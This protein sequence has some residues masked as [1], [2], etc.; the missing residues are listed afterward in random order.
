MAG[1]EGLLDIF[2]RH[3]DFIRQRFRRQHRDADLAIFRRGKALRV[4]F[5]KALQLRFRRCF[6]FRRGGEW[7]Q[8]HIRHAPFRLPHQQR[9]GQRI[10]RGSA[11][12]HGTQ[13]LLAQQITPDK[14]QELRFGQF[15][16]AQ[17][18]RQNLTR[19]LPIRGAQTRDGED[20]FAHHFLRRHHAHALGFRHHGAFADQIFQGTHGHGAADCLIRFEPIA[21]LARDSRHFTPRGHLRFLGFDPLISNPRHG[22]I[23]AKIAHNILNPPDSEGKDEQ[24]EKRLGDPGG[25]QATHKDDHEK[26]DYR[27]AAPRERPDACQAPKRR[28]ATRGKASP[29]AQEEPQHDPRCAPANRRQLENAWAGRRGPSFGPGRRR[30]RRWAEG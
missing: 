28:L 5:Q 3:R 29:Q 6:R 18:L 19:K 17:H 22:R 7:Q 8:H 21:H 23:A 11:R 10:R 9:R 16:A 4:V 2:Y 26:G 27:H 20:G 1:F 13:Q 30:W 15:I 25:R 12:A 24:D 14:R